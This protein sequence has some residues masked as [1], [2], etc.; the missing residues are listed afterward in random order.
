MHSPS[1]HTAHAGFYHRFK[2]SLPFLI[3]T[4]YLGIQNIILFLLRRLFLMTVYQTV[5]SY[6]AVSAG[7]LLLLFCCPV[8]VRGCKLSGKSGVS[9]PSAPKI[10][11]G[12]LRDSYLI[13]FSGVHGVILMGLLTC[14]SF[15]LTLTQVTLVQI[16]NIFLGIAL[17]WIFYMIFGKVSRAMAAGNLT[18][19]FFGI[20][21]RYL[22]RFRGAP[23]TLSDLKAA[24]T[25][26]NVASNYDFT[27][28]LLMLL[29]AVE[30]IL[31]WLAWKYYLSQESSDRS[32]SVRKY[33]WNLGIS[34]L[35]LCGLILLPVIRFDHIY[36]NTLQFSQ[37]T[38]FSTLLADL[39][40]N[41]KNLPENYSAETAQAVMEDYQ[42]T[43]LSN[44]A[45]SLSE[46][47]TG[48]ITAP[49]IVVIM[50]EAFSDLRV[51]GDFETTSP[52]L[53]YWDSLGENAVKG[54]ANVSVLGGSTANSEFEFLT[55]D[56]CGIFP[57]TIPYNSYFTASDT[58]PGLVSVLKEQGYETTVFHPY[59]A[60]GWNRTQ[61]YRAMQFDRVIFQE[62]LE[63]PLDTLRLYTSDL[64]DYQYITGLFDQKEP[65]V[66]QF[67]FNITMQNHG[68]YTYGG[69]DFRA[70]VQLT[71][72]A[73]GAFP[74]AEQYLSLVKESD[75]ALKYLLDYFT[76]YEEP[77]IVALFGDHQPCVE[78]GFYEYVTGLPPAA[79]DQQMLMNRY[80][81]PFIIWHNYETES[82]F[83]GDVSLNYLASLLLKD[84]GLSLSNYQEYVLTL[85]EN[86]PVYTGMGAI[87]REG[88]VKSRNDASVAE[89]IK[90]YRQIAVNH[91]QDV[92]GRW[93]DFFR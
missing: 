12:M 21:N 47:E 43:V 80:K 92:S 86:L 67:L 32:C 48:E 62:D 68:G 18:V 70:D 45:A 30:L 33:P 78:D 75:E 87:D 13:F 58:Y 5:I 83:A 85:Y 72:D 3:M 77:V 24:K 29:C 88:N 31:W 69:E 26:G 49:N 66:P 93:D 60:S 57:N 22:V 16:I 54:W 38:Y 51:L 15:Y 82:V 91:T 9:S 71:G 37:D 61:V 63:E 53:D 34:A 90:D 76:D 27:P 17:Y 11:P 35:I 10:F 64:A 79:W 73:A 46:E 59:L 81:T 23:F 84:A 55:S 4:G 65:G 19:G 28:D 8:T 7:A 36:A 74:Q 50:N 2:N 14:G 20:L 25:A 39:M 44:T 52:F 40:S 1:E 41:K 6:F 89:L 56:S 42:R